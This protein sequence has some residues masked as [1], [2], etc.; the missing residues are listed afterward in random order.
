MNIAII[1]ATGNVGSRILEEALR[2]GHSVIA[3]ARDAS[4]IAARANVT[5]RSADV[6]DTAALA[7]AIQ[8]ADVVVSSGRFASFKAADLL[9]AVKQAGVKRIAVVGGAGSLEI[10]P[11]K[12]LIDTP[13][14]PAE[15]KPEASA[16][17]DFLNDLRKEQDIA[18]TFLSPSALFVPGER[19]G[20]F[21]LGQDQLLVAA[22]GKSSISYEDFAIA[23]LDELEQPKHVRARF[24]VG[25]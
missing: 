13:E 22:D 10:A 21:R 20:K 1:G 7:A 24:T 18:W 3:I 8:G 17:R 11:G 23:L 9:P 12:A 14:F 5:A 6:K 2:R 16:G 19:T 4:K 25:Y 15:Y